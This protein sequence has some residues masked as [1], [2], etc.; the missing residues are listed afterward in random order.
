MTVNLGNFILNIHNPIISLILTLT[1]LLPHTRK[2]I[3]LLNN[4]AITS[5]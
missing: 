5:L 1:T 3:L 2:V 4:E